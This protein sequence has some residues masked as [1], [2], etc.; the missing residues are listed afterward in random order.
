M[1]CSKSCAPK[2][3]AEMVEPCAACQQLVNGDYKCMICNQHLHLPCAAPTTEEAI[4][5]ILCPNCSYVNA[6]V[7][8]EEEKS[9]TDYSDS[10]DGNSD[11]GGDDPLLQEGGD[12]VI[13]DDVPLDIGKYSF[14]FI[15][16]VCL[17][18]YSSALNGI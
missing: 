8:S 10:V 4:E 12:E 7:Q 15:L 16:N 5:D 13:V 9:D 17:D 18:C 6:N 2:Y 14:H 11:E 1:T 3:R